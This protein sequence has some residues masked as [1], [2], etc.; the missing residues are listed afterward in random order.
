MKIL[1]VNCNYLD[2]ML[3]QT[4]IKTLSKYGVEN[5]VFVPI[6]SVEGHV[7]KTLERYVKA[8]VCFNKVDRFAFHVKQ[9]KI[10]RAIKKS[11]N[12]SS[13][14]CLHAYTVFTDGNVTR[15]LS[16]EYGIPY[17]VAVR[18]TDVN[19]F[20]KYMAHLRSTGVSVLRDAS[21]IFFLSNTYKKE[22]LENYVP[23]EL[24]QEIERKSY[25][26]PN[27]IDEFWHNNKFVDRPYEK[28]VSRFKEKKLNLLY[29]GDIDHNKNV[30]ETCEA[31][32]ILQNKGWKIE[33]DV[34]GQI[35]SQSA[36]NRIKP[37]VEYH[38]RQPKEKL[39]E[40]FREADIFVMPSHT[41][42]FGLVY[43]EAMSQGLP[44]IYTRGQ[45]FDGQFREGE[46]GYAVSDSAP[47]ELSERIVSCV[48]NYEK[49][50]MAGLQGVSKYRWNRICEWYQEKYNEILKI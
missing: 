42:T 24:R 39:I 48:E 38:Q 35:K 14:D 40:Y 47:D 28:I 15:K 46:V 17:V 6:Y 8:K 4:M 44:I 11:Y 13:F 36:F 1:H 22:V 37:L 50:S 7:V 5:E 2:S 49:I 32:K 33:F 10:Y 45:G 23:Q 12:I 20:F 41:E 27:G 18:N 26:V 31:I 21:A 43:V 16:I 34:V 29:V 9:S 19:T 3:H 30:E 25:I